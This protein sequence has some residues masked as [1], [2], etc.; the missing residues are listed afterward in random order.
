VGVG[1][2]VSS[3]VHDVALLTHGHWCANRRCYVDD[4]IPQIEGSN[5]CVEDDDCVVDSV[6]N[7]DCGLP[8]DTPFF[9]A[10]S[11]LFCAPFGTEGKKY[12]TIGCRIYIPPACADDGSTVNGFEGEMRYCPLRLDSETSLID[13]SCPCY[14]KECANA[15]VCE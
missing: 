3:L 9:V 14:F 15:T 13:S 11:N 2:V 6:I 8:E 10:G 1:T 7:H 4:R 12:C 5:E